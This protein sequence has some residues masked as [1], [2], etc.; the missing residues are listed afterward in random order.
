MSPPGW[1]RLSKYKNLAILADHVT[2]PKGVRTRHRKGVNVLYGNG[3][4]KW[5]DLSVFKTELDKCDEP[6]SHTYDPYVVNIWKLLD[7]Q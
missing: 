2:S 7:Q 6:F 1:P 4:A 5:V 3:S